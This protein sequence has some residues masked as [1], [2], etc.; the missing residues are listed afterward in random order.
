MKDN[1]R[2]EN[3]R[4]V[5]AAFLVGGLVGTFFALLYAPQSGRETRKDISK[6]ARR[7]KNKAVDV[8]EEAIEDVDDFVDNLRE[9]AADIMD[10]GM[11]ISDRARKQIAKTL[12]HGQSVIEKQRK[13]ISESLGL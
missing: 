4:V 3:V 6:T 8:L 11:D 2:A 9:A 13:K 1:L 10:Q 5:G 12:S 7:V